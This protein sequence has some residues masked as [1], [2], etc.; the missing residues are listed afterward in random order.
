M[1]LR[2]SALFLSAFS[3]LKITHDKEPLLHSKAQPWKS[4]RGRCAFH[5]K[6]KWFLKCVVKRR[7]RGENTRRGPQRGMRGGGIE[8]DIEDIGLLRET[9]VIREIRKLGN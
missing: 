5:Q 9:R 3:A 6:V 2:L 7:V 4:G 1:P 8:E